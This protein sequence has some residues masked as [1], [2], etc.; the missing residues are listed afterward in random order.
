M[1]KKYQKLIDSFNEAPRKK[2]RNKANN[3]TKQETISS[4]DNFY[5]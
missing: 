2:E 5:I 4:C 1:Y 3:K